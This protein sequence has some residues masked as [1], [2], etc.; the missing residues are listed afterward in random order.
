MP[1][2]QWLLNLETGETRPTRCGRLGCDF[3]VR[4]NARRRAGAIKHAA[5]Q[6]A[7]LLTQVGDDWDTVRARVNRIR[8]DIAAAVGPFEWVWHVEPNPAGT[9]HHVHAWQHG[10]FVPQV[11]LASVA[12]RR[13]CGGVVFVNRIRSTA[14]AATYGLK[15]MGYGLKGVDQDAPDLYLSTNGKRLTHQSRGFFRDGA[16]GEKLAVRA[17]ERAAVKTWGGGAEWVLVRLAA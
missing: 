17:A 15:G 8:Y 7:I 4:A 10:N 16:S 14:G 12:R 2:D 3:C 9:G 13:G 5:P 6:R 1:Q 11:T